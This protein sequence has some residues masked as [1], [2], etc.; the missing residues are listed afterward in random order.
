[1]FGLFIFNNCENEKTDGRF[2]QQLPRITLEDFS[3]TETKSGKKLWTINAEIAKVFDEIIKVDSVEV[4]F[5]DENQVQF[6]MLVAPSG[7]LNTKTRNMRVG[8]SVTVL[9]NDSTKLFAD[10]L[11][12]FNDSQK[13]YTNSYVRIIKQDSTVIE[14]NGLKTDPYLKK[15][16]II[17]DTKGVSPIELPDINE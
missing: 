5:Y 14:G 12:W 1:M 11:F 15:I 2:N 7:E 3:L 10:S 4:I 8:D 17:G 16:E 13:I 9:T 6:S